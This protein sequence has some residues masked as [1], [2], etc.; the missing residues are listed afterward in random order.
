MRGMW[1]RATSQGEWR[2]IVW[3]WN[4]AIRVC[5]MCIMMI[6]NLVCRFNYPRLRWCSVFTNL[7]KMR[8]KRNFGSLYKSRAMLGRIWRMELLQLLS[9]VYR[10]V[11]LLLPTIDNNAPF[12]G[13]SSLLHS[14]KL[15]TGI[16][17]VCCPKIFHNNTLKKRL[18]RMYLEYLG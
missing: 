15:Q 10:L 12:N 3:R 13:V 6:M 1:G 7:R 4:R 5:N 8:W 17:P 2:A 11:V 14:F 9:W 16:P 18:P